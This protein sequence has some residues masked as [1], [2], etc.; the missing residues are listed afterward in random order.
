MN[1]PDR[2]NPDRLLAAINSEA[3]R[4]ARGRLKVFL[5]MCAGVGKT[6]AMLEAARRELAA[7][8]DVVVGYLETHGR[9]ETDALA[10]GLP[11]IPRRLV[12]YRGVKLSEFDLDATLAR[13]PS[14]VL[15]DEFA[16]TNAPESR[17]PKR[18]QDVA[19]LLNAGID[20]FTTLNI[21]HIESRAEVVRQITGVTIQEM[22]SDSAL[23]G[24][25]LELIDLPPDE[26]RARLAAGK[27][28]LVE[29]A[30]TAQDKF[31]RPGNLSALR[32]LALR[33]AAEHVGDT[34]RAYRQAQGVG[35]PWKSGQRLLVA[36][37][38]SPSSASLIRW[39]KRLAGELN[40]TWVAVY[41]E[42]ARPLTAEDKTRLDS[43]L[44]QARSLGAEIVNTSDED[45][46]RA[47]LRTAREQNATQ[48]VVGK[49]LGWR[50]L[51][52]WRGGS[53]LNR[54]I[55]E[56]GQIDIHAV[57]P[58]PGAIVATKPSIEWDWEWD[59]S[60]YGIA[61]LL[62]GLTTLVNWWLSHWLTGQGLALV[63]LGSTV[64]IAMVFSRGVSLFAAG[65]S[66]LLWDWFFTEPRFSLRITNSTDAI[67]F[68]TYFIVAVAMGQLTARLRAQQKAERL[69]EQRATAL[70]LFTRELAES[71]D[72]AQLFAVVIKQVGQTFDANVALSLPEGEKATI[73]TWYFASSWALAE[74]EQSVANWAF[75]RGQSAGRG[76]DT[77]PAAEGLHLPL[78]AGERITG[79]LSLSFHKHEPL[80][81]AQ[82]DLL[83]AFCRQI[84]LV[85]DRERLRDHETQAQLLAESERLSKTLLDSIS[86]EFRTPLA[87]INGAVST[88]SESPA[89]PA[90][91][92]VEMVREIQLATTRLN[93]LVGNLLDVTRIESGHVRMRLDWHDVNDLI[94]STLEGVARELQAHPVSVSIAPE[95]KLARLD[96]ALTQEALSNLLLNAATH[97]PPGTPVEL[98]VS[99]KGD[100]VEFRVSDQGPGIP[101]EYQT[102]IFEKFVRTAHAPAG[103]SGLGLAIV[104]GFVEAQGGTISVENNAPQGATFRLRLPYCE[105]PT[106]G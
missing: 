62:V 80:S 50:W 36:V 54:L 19:E 47:I 60:A 42:G 27:V 101:A 58:D 103:G 44:S 74:K 52:V 32:E 45:I 94:Q 99:R 104:K 46:V 49:P 89:P 7:G 70:Y 28:Y 23:E 69:R 86:H 79:V 20:V 14:L 67:M 106:E 61:G 26:L 8:R 73:P 25:E 43:H 71:S 12:D 10:T 30:A 3:A 24:A 18:W 9:K 31:F 97:T 92:Q 96:F 17:H 90:V 48:I 72:I 21:Q 29:R 6:Y 95:V 83:D 51:E 2:P 87:A 4:S 63:Y 22:V 65:T 88:L 56:S 1:E 64:A 75:Q 41:V 39:A 78:R 15:V 91:L 68:T 34:V 102:R 13:K 81:T 93:R 77:L 40:A 53:F 82:R 37:S 66:A 100:W 57:S 76:T 59:W 11:T 105:P 5:G 38:S 55:Y 84:S 33:F 16:H 85:L 98:G 35:A